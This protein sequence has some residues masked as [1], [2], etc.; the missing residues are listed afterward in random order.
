MQT[1]PD[2][3]IYVLCPAHIVTGGIEAVHQ[4]VDKLRMFGHQ[5]KIKTIPRVPN[6]VLLQYRNYDVEF[7]DEIEDSARNILI[8]TEVNPGELD[9][10]QHIQ[11]ILWWLSVDNYKQR[12]QPFDFYSPRNRDVLHCVQSAYADSYLRRQGIQQ[13]AYLTDYLHD[14]YLRRV[15]RP[16]K[17]LAL[18]T[19]AKGAEL[20]VR[21]LMQAD[22]SIQWLPLKN[23]IRSQHA[24]TLR[25]G[26]VYVDFGSHPGKDRQPR[27]AA[28]NQCCV[29]VG[30]RG[31]ACFDADLPI[32]G[33]YRFDVQPLDTESILATI[34]T[35][36]DDYG[37]RRHDFDDYA[38]LVRRE[39]RR[40]EDEVRAIFGCKA[41][42]HRSRQQVILRNTWSFLAQ[43]SPL[44]AMRGLANEFLPLS[45]MQS[46]KRSYRSLKAMGGS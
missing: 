18:Y 21:Q 23:M 17:N 16:K 37:Q 35:C 12:G 1:Y 13:T 32:P 11:K 7:A 38:E 19:P 22:P 2:S 10:Y 27:E 26:K 36:L 31:S 5:A 3:I 41:A 8:T 34:R 42:P 25:E 45:L 14:E 28:V 29:V 6:P 4:L 9:R 43:N 15:I 44:T 30:A 24:Q 40:F 46:L 20:I 33:R 39:E